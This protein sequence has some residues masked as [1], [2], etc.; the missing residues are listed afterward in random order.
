MFLLGGKQRSL[1]PGPSAFYIVRARVHTFLRAFAGYDTDRVSLTRPTNYI[2]RNNRVR[3]ISVLEAFGSIF[4][5]S[6]SLSV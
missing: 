2:T 1:S 6:L 4:S 3:N 5:L